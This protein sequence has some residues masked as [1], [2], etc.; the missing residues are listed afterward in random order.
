MSCQ[1]QEGRKKVAARIIK[2]NTKDLCLV[3]KTLQ[4]PTSCMLWYQ[5]YILQHMKLTEIFHHCSK[6]IKGVVCSKNVKHKRM[7]SQH[8]NPR[9][10][11]LG[12]SLEYHKVSNKLASLNNVLQQVLPFS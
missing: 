2:V 6:L 8:V 4:V 12:G 3:N 7:V 9:L 11:L 10:L 5:P 1:A